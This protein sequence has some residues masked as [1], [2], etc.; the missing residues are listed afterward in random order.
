MPLVAITRDQLTQYIE[1]FW[2]GY[3][4]TMAELEQA[5]RVPNVNLL[6]D[7][8]NVANRV[9]EETLDDILLNGRTDYGWDSLLKSTAVTAVDAAANAAGDS[10]E[11]VKKTGLEMAKDM[12]DAIDGIYTATTTVLRGDTLLL[13]PSAYQLA[14]RTPMSESIPNITVLRW[15]R[16][17]NS[18]TA[19]TGQP[20]MIAECRGL[21][22]AGAS[23]A[24]RLIAY[25]KDMD[26]LRY[27]IPYTFRFSAPYMSGPYRYVVPGMMRCGGLEI[28]QPAGVRYIDGITS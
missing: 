5:R 2:V 18:Y 23:D 22:N 12:N 20:L 27:H 13:P 19:E 4:Y 10:K 14:S 11:W 7:K 16:E 28:R 1:S 24:G 25:R 3:D 17:N 8:T 26:V 15:V 6:G 9:M 21:E